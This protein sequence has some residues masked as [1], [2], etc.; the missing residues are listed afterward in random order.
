MKTPKDIFELLGIPSYACPRH[1]VGQ[2]SGDLLLVGG[3]RTLWEDTR[4]L[5]HPSNTMCVNDV[6]MYWPGKVTHWYSNDVD[7]LIHWCQG[8]RRPYKYYGGHG[9]LHTCTPRSGPDYKGVTFWPFPTQGSSGIV[10]LYVA[11]A[12]GYDQITVVGMPWDDDGHFFDPPTGH[13]LSE[14]R[15]WTNFTTE[16]PEIYLKRLLPLC[17]GRVRAVS[18]RLK[19]L[20]EG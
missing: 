18:G 17:I 15:S 3:G 8:R 6:G 20:L 10:A 1:H 5:P 11:L 2:Y 14:G 7:Q 13:S 19:T 12:M 16:T 9:H 4:G